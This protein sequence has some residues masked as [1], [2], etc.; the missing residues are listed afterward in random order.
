MYRQLLEAALG[1][2][3]PWFVSGVDFD[4]A[5]KRPQDHHHSRTREPAVFALGLGE[6]LQVFVR[7]TPREGVHR[8]AFRAF[9]HVTEH[10]AVHQ[11]SDL[12]TTEA[13]RSAY[14]SQ[15]QPAMRPLELAI[16]KSAQN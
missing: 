7:V 10:P 9:E 6:R 14:V 2:S 3:D 8:R 12:S 11:A 15:Y 5:A 4:A 13:T 16:A 1:V